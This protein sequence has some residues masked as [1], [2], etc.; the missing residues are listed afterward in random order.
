LLPLRDAPAIRDERGDSRQQAHRLAD[1]RG[2]RVIVQ[3]GIERPE[4]GNAG[5]QHVHR[6]RVFRHQL[7]HFQNWL[8]QRAVRGECFRKFRQ[9]LRRRQLAVQQQVGDLLEVRLL[10][11]LMDVVAAV[12]QAR[13]WVD[14]ANFRFAGD[15]PGQARAVAWFCFSSHTVSLKIVSHR[16][17]NDEGLTS[18]PGTQL[19]AP[20]R[21]RGF[22]SSSFRRVQWTP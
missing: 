5:P 4:H 16:T 7:E 2:M 1:I 15:H 10:R 12:H 13:V 22:I 9:F 17:W 3:I 14:P 18:N 21:T 6:V 11:H 19:T 20:G 8:R